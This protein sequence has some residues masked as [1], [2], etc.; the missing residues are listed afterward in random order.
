M[1]ILK[2]INLYILFKAHKENVFWINKKKKKQITCQEIIPLFFIYF[3]L[4]NKMIAMG[5]VVHTRY[6]YVC[7]YTIQTQG[8][9]AHTIGHCGQQYEFNSAVCV[10]TM[11]MCAVICTHI[12]M[13][14]TPTYS[15]KLTIYYSRASWHL[16][17]RVVPLPCGWMFTASG[18]RMYVRVHKPTQ[19]SH[20]TEKKRYI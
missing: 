11:M 4:S 7:L 17:C 13:Q 12:C 15:T 19:V 1:N 8:F 6:I 14:H 10:C 2:I 20:K 3:S 16:T 18:V 9:L 5:F